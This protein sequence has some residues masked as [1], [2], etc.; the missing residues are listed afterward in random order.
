MSSSAG[1]QPSEISILARWIPSRH[2]AGVILSPSLD[3]VGSPRDSWDDSFASQFVPLPASNSSSCVSLDSL[4]LADTGDPDQQGKMKLLDAHG[5]AVERVCLDAADRKTSDCP[6]AQ[7]LEELKELQRAMQEQLKSHRMEQLHQ[8]LPE[9][10]R[11]LGTVG[12]H[13]STDFAGSSSLAGEGSVTEEPSQWALLAGCVGISTPPQTISNPPAV[14]PG[15]PLL[16]VQSLQWDPNTVPGRAS[17]DVV[18]EQESPHSQQYPETNL[19]SQKGEAA[20]DTTLGADVWEQSYNRDQHSADRSYKNAESDNDDRELTTSTSNDQLPSPGREDEQSVPPSED[21]PIKPGVGSKKQTFEEL[22]EEQLQLEEQRMKAF[23]LGQTTVEVKAPP[24][25]TFLR[26]GEGL[27]RFTRGKAALPKRRDKDAVIHMS[28]KSSTSNDTGPSRNIQKN[29]VSQR[30][31]IQRKTTVLNK[32]NRP[33]HQPVGQEPRRPQTKGA[34]QPQTKVLGRNQRQNIGAPDL[35]R[36][37]AGETLERNGKETTSSGLQGRR[38]VPLSRPP[39]SK[40]VLVTKY[41]SG[42]EI[43][44]VQRQ[45]QMRPTPVAPQPPPEHSFELSFQEKLERWASEKLQENAE[46]GEFELL[47]QAAEELSFSSN[48]SFVMKVLQL[49]RQNSRGGHHNRRLSSTPIKSL[50]RRQSAEKGCRPPICTGAARL[51]PGG[52]QPGTAGQKK[53]DNLKVKEAQA[54]TNTAATRASSHSSLE[55]GDPD[56]TVREVEVAPA[57]LAL[58]GHLCFPVPSAA[59]YDRMSY[60]DRDIDLN[61]SKGKESCE[62]EF[63]QH[64]GTILTENGETRTADHIVFDD[65]D[66]WNDVEDA[67]DLEEEEE[68]AGDDEDGDDDDDDETRMGDSDHVSIEAISHVPSDGALKRKVAAVKGEDRGLYPKEGDQVSSPPPTSQLVAKLFPSVKPKVKLGPAAAVEPPKAVAEQVAGPNPLSRQ[69]RERLVELETEIERFKEEN[70]KLAHLKQQ[71]EAGLEAL[72]KDVVAFEQRKAKE[73]ADLEEVKKGEAQKLQRERKVFERHASAARAMP[74]KKEREEIQALKQQ[75]S[76]LQDELR[77]REARWSNTHSRLRKQLETVSAENAALRDEVRVLEK[78]RVAT[79]KKAEGEK[80]KSTVQ[81]SESFQASSRRSK[82]DSPT[83][84]TC[85]TT[86]LPS[87][88]RGSVQGHN[89]PGTGKPSVHWAEGKKASDLGRGTVVENSVSPDC[90]PRN[91]GALVRERC[92]DENEEDRR[93]DEVES[94]ETITHPDGKIEHVLRWGGRLILFPN[95]TRKEVSADGRTVKITFFNGDVKQVTDDQQVIY[96]YAEAQTTHTT[97]PDGMEV[98]RFPNNQI[99]KHFPDGR[100]EITFPDQ[101]VKNLFPDGKEESI[102]PDGTV[103]EAEPDGSK[104]IRFNNGQREVHTAAFKRREY[105]DGTAK[106]IYADGRQETSYPTGRL[107]V[108]DKDGHVVMDTMT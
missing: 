41:V 81:T 85:D 7:K 23:R 24:K 84:T 33:E 66:T 40:A 76:S 75:L 17:L 88:T 18:G 80:E 98:L 2:R 6:I 30:P 79:W 74:D 67:G 35:G 71:R 50:E 19:Y 48:S 12:Q 38:L 86:L 55:F 58:H 44:G 8:P 105:P 42:E 56:D 47:E 37:K 95:G 15:L 11:F 51:K 103:I 10:Q 102:F 14:R 101:T 90:L 22:L 32:E 59:L 70:A 29:K 92:G 16:P 49:D 73:L 4:V 45:M 21:R 39:T 82:S 106:T 64:A 94:Q 53:S 25:R 31:A 46:L 5:I 26:R 107:R 61:H 69:L 68:T 91:S 28:P 43:S 1:V 97:Y 93:Q 60:Q 13:S 34:V 3:G 9:P 83:G 54:A 77:R 89:P 72:R 36:S 100:K 52:P 20:S 65:D 27:A 96:Y 87:S 104:V 78:L 63:S 99:E 57:E 62:V 108:K